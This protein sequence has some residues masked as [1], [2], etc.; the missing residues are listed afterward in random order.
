MSIPCFEVWL[1]EERQMVRQRIRGAPDLTQFLQMSAATGECASRLRCPT[2]VCI[3][4][5]GEE[6]GRLPKPTRSVAMETLKRPDLK[7][8]AIVTSSRFGRI[9]LRFIVV[10]TGIDK[11]RAFRDKA[12]ALKWL[13]S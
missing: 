8:V 9:M 10:A 6:L 11:V 5:E 2:E 12:E 7:R 1:D 4:V 3:L 13:Q